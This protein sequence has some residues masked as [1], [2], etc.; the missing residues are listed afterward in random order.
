MKKSEAMEIIIKV[1]ENNR[2]KVNENIQAEYDF[3]LEEYEANPKN[4]TAEDLKSL[5]NKLVK[6]GLVKTKTDNQEEAKPKAE[7]TAKG[8]TTKTTKTQK[9]TKKEE[10]V[11]EPKV[12][13]PKKEGDENNMIKANTKGTAKNSTPKNTKGTTAKKGNK[14]AENSTKKVA[15]KT[16][17]MTNVEEEYEFKGFP[18]TLKSELGNLKLATDIKTMEDLSNAVDEERE[19]VIANAWV[20]DMLKTYEYDPMGILDEEEREKLEEDGFANDL[21]LLQITFCTEKVAY[22]VSLYTE[23]HTTYVPEGFE[24]DENGLRNNGFINYQVYEITK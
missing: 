5:M 22:A 18:K 24:V 4:V 17:K 8:K 16:V 9:E 23:V 21:D 1:V 6:E 7:T 13:E 19:I 20:V 2:G 15:P 3:L 11:V 14:K 12:D 10:K